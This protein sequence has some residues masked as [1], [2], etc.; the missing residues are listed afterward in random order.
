M[1][2]GESLFTIAILGALSYGIYLIHKKRKWKLMGKIAGVVVL[3]SILISIGIY[4]YNVYKNRPTVQT[5][6]A[7]ISIGMKK[8]DV[9]LI[10]GKPDKEDVSEEGVTTLMYTDYS[11]T[12][13]MFVTLDAENNEVY[14][15]CSLEFYDEVFGLGEYDSLEKVTNK[16]GEAPEKSINADGTMMIITYPQYNVAFQI[17]EGDVN[18][19][20]VTTQEKMGYVEEY[21]NS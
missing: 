2:T 8:V 20:C 17:F 3:I 13:E 5:E 15:I 21:L 10:K 19:T 4:G 7:G 11:G 1:T 16:L 14:R 12:L 18:M 9:T 6:L